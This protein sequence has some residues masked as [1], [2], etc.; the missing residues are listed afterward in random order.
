MLPTRGPD[1]QPGVRAPTISISRIE[2][3]NLIACRHLVNPAYASVEI[4]S[5]IHLLSYIAAE[6]TLT[7]MYLFD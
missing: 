5:F 3:P 7:V 1:A 2:I 4:P 6:R